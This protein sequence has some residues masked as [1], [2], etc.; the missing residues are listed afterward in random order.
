MHESVVA[1][2]DA[3]MLIGM[4]EVQLMTITGDE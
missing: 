4:D 2:L 1:A 3:R